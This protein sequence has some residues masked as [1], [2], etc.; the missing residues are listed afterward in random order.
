MDMNFQQLPSACRAGRERRP[1]RTMKPGT[2]GTYDSNDKWEV[3][4]A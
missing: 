3:D 4:P 2:L 1:T